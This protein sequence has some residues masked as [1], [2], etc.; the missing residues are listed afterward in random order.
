MIFP[1]FISPI[2]VQY[3]NGVPS[4]NEDTSYKLLVGKLA[5][6]NSNNPTSVGILTYKLLNPWNYSFVWYLGHGLKM[7]YSR[8][9]VIGPSVTGN[10]QLSNFY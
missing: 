8:H 10:I 5:T 9:S 7:D 1:V 6:N 4:S 2:L 3:L